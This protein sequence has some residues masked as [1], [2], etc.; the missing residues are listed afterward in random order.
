MNWIIRLN[1]ILGR[2]WL[3]LF[4]LPDFITAVEF[5]FF[6]YCQLTE[7]QILNLRYGQICADT[8]IQQSENP[9]VILLDQADLHKEWHDWHYFLTAMTQTEV[10]RGTYDTSSSAT[11]QEKDA[12]K[13]AGWVIKPSS[14]IDRPDYLM[15]HLVSPKIM[16]FRGLDFDFD[17]GEFL[18]YA[19]LTSLNLPTVKTTDENGMLHINYKLFAVTVQTGRVCDPVN[20]FESNKLNEFSPTVWDMHQ[21][22]ATFYNVKKL[23]ADVTGCVVA[24][25]DGVITAEWTE[26]PYKCLLVD[27]KVYCSKHE[28][29]LPDGS[30]V[31]AGDVLYGPMVAYKGS[32]NPT[33]EQV[34]GIR[35]RTDAGELFAENRLQPAYRTSDG[36]DTIPLTGHPT[37]LAKYRRICELNTADKRCPYR[38]VPV[39]L[40]PYKFITQTVRRGRCMA[41]RLVATSVEKLGAALGCIRRN[42]CESGIISVYVAA[43]TEPANVSVSFEAEAGMMA[44][45]VEQTLTIKLECAEARVFL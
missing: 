18:F 12:Y 25:E 2:F 41:I 6:K 5:L 28:P 36:I 8:R 9:V 38:K 7:A 32:D 44:V 43:E 35:V 27:D 24:E 3:D 4:G 1:Q 30:N 23:L 42:T 10:N 16:L 45:S 26:G 19:D 21:N 22:G 37:V 13:A 15:D 29:N 33:I 14:T 11:Q 20:G 40:N 39:T 17:N 34:P 31:Q